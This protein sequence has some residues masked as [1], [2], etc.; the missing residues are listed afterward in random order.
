MGIVEDEY[1]DDDDENYDDDDTWGRILVE[2]KDLEI[3]MQ[4]GIGGGS[5]SATE[6]TIRAIERCS[7]NGLPSLATMDM[8]GWTLRYSDGYTN[9]GNCINPLN[10]PTEDLGSLIIKCEEFFRSYL[11]PTIFKLTDASR[12]QGIQE[13]LSEKE[14]FPHSSRVSVQVADLVNINGS[15][16]EYDGLEFKEESNVSFSWLMGFARLSHLPPEHLNPLAMMLQ[17]I[18]RRSLFIRIF[19][20]GEC[21]ACGYGVVEGMYLGLFDI[22]VAEEDR[23]QGVGEMAMKHIMNWGKENGAEKAYLQ[24]IDTNTPALHLYE[25][26]RFRTAYQYWYLMKTY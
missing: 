9:R 4:E 20:R 2:E 25:K 5:Q 8:G 23:R 3:T 15:T 6:D 10:E 14:Y 19:R 21:I 1:D 11:Q 7:M 17:Q 26:F 16:P 13:L 18:D 22:V 12:P 24:V